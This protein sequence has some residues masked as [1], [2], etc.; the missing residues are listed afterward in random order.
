MKLHL[1]GSHLVKARHSELD[2]VSAKSAD[3]SQRRSTAR[4]VPHCISRSTPA[5]PA[6]WPS[7]NVRRRGQLFNGPTARRASSG[8]LFGACASA[9][10]AVPKCAQACP[11]RAA[12][13]ARTPARRRYRPRRRAADRRPPTG[14]CLINENARLFASRGDQPLHTARQ[15]C[16]RLSLY[17]LIDNPS[18]RG[19]RDG[20]AGD[21]RKAPRRARA[22]A[23][24]RAYGTRDVYIVAER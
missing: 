23:D 11:G 20:P 21:C 10:P 7:E 14:L 13:G 24:G 22:N 1:F 3:L 16:S 4:V 5:L 2:L 12:G 17:T 18:R 8:A 15:R 19:A 9:G 6:A